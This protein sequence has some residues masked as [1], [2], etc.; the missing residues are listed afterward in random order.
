[1]AGAFALD[2]GSPY[3]D[4]AWAVKYRMPFTFAHPAAVIPL[5]RLFRR[6]GVL[7]ALVIGS[8][9]PDLPYFVLVSVA[10]SQSHSVAGL[11]QFCLPASLIAYL[12]FHLLFKGPLL[13]L[14]PEGWFNRLG[15]VARDYKTLPSVSWP[16]TIVCLLAGASTHVVWDSFT[17]DSSVG[18]FSLRWLQILLFYAWGY[19]IYIYKA[20]QHG[21]T[22]FGMAI[23]VKWARQWYRQAPVAPVSL[24]LMLNRRQ[25]AL[26]LA[27]IFLFPLAYGIS[28]AIPEIGDD[29]FLG[30]F[31]QFIGNAGYTILPTFV[32]MIVLYSGCWHLWRMFGSGR[33]TPETPQE[34]DPQA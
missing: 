16:A 19:P 26:A 14:M 8:M 1:M 5:Y 22:I 13:S 17:H 9:S 4:Q 18:L 25:A 3:H 6:K 31:H 29:D 24:P 32:L 21:S 20:L 27:G 12:V 10:R 15:Q 30:E 2:D 28:F 33:Q 34:P 23:L 7:S 11:F